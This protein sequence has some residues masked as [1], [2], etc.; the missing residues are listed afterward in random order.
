M[1]D[2]ERDADRL[3]E[4]YL[5]RPNPRPRTRE[6]WLAQLE[7]WEGKVNIESLL[8]WGGYKGWSLEEP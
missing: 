5:R 6:E 1:T 7:E 3:L 4:A 2:A 8:V